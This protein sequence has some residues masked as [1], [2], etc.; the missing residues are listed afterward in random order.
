MLK[1][2]FSRRDNSIIGR[3]WWTIDRWTLGALIV[4]MTIGILLSFAASPAVADRLNLG[5]FFFVKKHLFML[6]PSF[7]LLILVSMMMPLYIRR[8][9][10]LL[11]LVGGVLLIFTLV[12]GAEVKGARRWINIGSF[13]LQASEFVKP[14]FAVVSAWM[15]SEKLRYPHFP[16]LSLSLGLLSV[17]VILLLLQ[18]DLGM[19]VVTVSTWIGQ[20]FIAGIPLFW[21]G[22]VGGFAISGMLGAY[23]F[24]PHVAR[25]IDQFLDPTSGDPR[26]DL[27][28][29]TQSLEAFKNGGLFGRGPGEGIVK[30]HIPDVHADFVFAVA[31]EEF[32][33]AVCLVIVAL[34]SFVVIR[35]FLRLVNEQSL[36]VIL[37]ASGIVLQFGLQAVI[38]LAS[39]LHIIP[40]KG[41]TLPFV[42]YGGSSMLALGIGMG[43]VL[44]LTRK[45]HGVG[46]MV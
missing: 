32:G 41:M 14:A 35:S 13:S 9:A 46:E 45:R 39:T 22:C 11:Y 34:F 30:K 38:N 1:E 40:T 29:V 17:I 28:Q 44:A 4:L 25:R 16:G 19:T 8:L 5:G 31:G 24:F 15:I 10:V 3:W 27:Y 43:M 2:T 26:H 36:F 12:N 23:F 37:A 21:I 6:I 7:G 18:P 42:S 33:L 20:L